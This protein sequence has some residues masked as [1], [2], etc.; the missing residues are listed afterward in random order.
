MGKI[1]LM[2]SLDVLKFKI[3]KSLQQFGLNE[4][5]TI[6]NQML[7]LSLAKLSADEVDLI[8][9]DLDNPDHDAM[10]V[11]KKLKS[12]KSSKLIP[13]VAIGNANDKATMNKVIL[14]GCVEY[15]NKPLDDLTFV[16]KIHNLIKEFKLS[17]TINL[18]SQ[19]ETN[20][21]HQL[22]DSNL[23]S[24]TN[25]ID[26]KFTWNPNFETGIDFI[27]VAHQSIV[28]EYEKLYHMMK[29][30]K[31]H[32]Y[33]KEL[34]LFLVQYCENHLVAEEKYM[35]ECDYFDKDNHISKHRFFIDKVLMYKDKL[36]SPVSNEDLIRINLFIKEWL[37]QHLSFEDKKMT[38]ALKNIKVNNS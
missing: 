36:N 28:E 9:I 13:I 10:D 29:I 35:I 4:T 16:G 1:A 32:D 26:I 19:T 12:S 23:D 33:Y 15:F 21:Q 7:S 22:H 11:I 37:I 34:L 2:V 27:D 18:V 31:G 38:V 17:Q 8:I 14:S 30:G 25:F 6:G 24:I 3:E 20:V 5:M